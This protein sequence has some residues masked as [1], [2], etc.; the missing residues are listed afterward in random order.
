MLHNTISNYHV[1][2]L[3]DDGNP[4]RASFQRGHAIMKNRVSTSD[5]RACI[6][7]MLNIP[8]ARFPTLKQSDKALARDIRAGDDI[9]SHLTSVLDK[10]FRYAPEPYRETFGLS[11]VAALAKAVYDSLAR[12]EKWAE[13]AKLDKRYQCSRG[14]YE[15][16]FDNLIFYGD[17]E[18]WGWWKISEFLKEQL[19]EHANNAP[20]GKAVTY[21]IVLNSA[22]RA[23]DSVYGKYLQGEYRLPE[24]IGGTA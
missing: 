18:D 20:D 6:K 23:L 13:I 9:E 3:F 1:A 5:R 16:Y 2:C 15:D 4:V 10:A 24:S 14:S 7:W 17:S 12:F 21:N 8:G 22:L 11:I 19:R